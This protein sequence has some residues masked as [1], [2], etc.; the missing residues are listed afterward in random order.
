MR[1]VTAMAIK[2]TGPTH[3]GITCS[4]SGMVAVVVAGWGADSP[5]GAGV[6][7]GEVVSDGSGTGVVSCS[8]GAGDA[9]VGLFD[10][11]V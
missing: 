2:T 9:G 5:A 10:G 4:G 11:A 8:G 6:L 7:P 3:Q 1:T